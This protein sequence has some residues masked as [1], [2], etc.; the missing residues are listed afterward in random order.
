MNLL[1]Y[2][3]LC[4]FQKIIYNSI[5]K[6]KQVFMKAIEIVFTC[7]NDKDLLYNTDCSDYLLYLHKYSIINGMN[8]TIQQLDIMNNNWGFNINDFN[9]KIGNIPIIAFHGNNDALV[10]LKFVEE[11]ND[12]IQNMQL[13]VFEDKGH[14]CFLCEDVIDECLDIIAKFT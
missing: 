9:N 11:L 2:P 1:K 13:K 14:M 5:L 6:N 7:K 10:P 12:N 4:Y 8:G 3:M